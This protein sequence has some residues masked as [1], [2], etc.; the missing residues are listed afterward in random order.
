MVVVVLEVSVGR[1]NVILARKGMCN[2][3]SSLGGV[4][5]MLII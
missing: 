5:R 1:H 3:V 4:V 2:F